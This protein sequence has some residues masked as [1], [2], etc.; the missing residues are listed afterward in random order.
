MIL[1]I[2][3]IV[4]IIATMRRGYRTGLLDNVIRTAGWIIGLIASL[5]LAPIFKNFLI[6]NTNWDEAIYLRVSEKTQELLTPT[7]VGSGLPDIIEES[8]LELTN[9]VAANAADSL[10]ESLSMLW[11]SVISFVMVAFICNLAYKV[12]LASNSKKKRRSIIGTVDGVAGAIF[13]F[14]K[15]IFY[16]FIALALL[17]PVAT[18]A[19]PDTYMMLMDSLYESNIALELYDNNLLMLIIEDLMM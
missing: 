5:V 3:V 2:L 8:F 16:V 12:A 6:D 7:Q 13:G 1:D 19:N 17:F 10:A 9:T 4:I 14:V 11:M 15:A 18:M